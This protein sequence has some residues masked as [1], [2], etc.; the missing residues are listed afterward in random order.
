MGAGTL[1]RELAQRGLDTGYEEF[2]RQSEYPK[3]QLGFLSALLRG[4]QVPTST[5]Q[6]NTQTQAG[7]NNGLA[8]LLGLASGAAGAVKLFQ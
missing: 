6:V 2:I 8:S 5:S 4:S 3:T 1:Q 7:G